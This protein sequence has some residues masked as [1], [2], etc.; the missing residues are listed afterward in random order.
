MSK[1]I[2]IFVL[3]C[4][5]GCNMDSSTS[6]QLNKTP[7]PE[8]QNETPKPKDQPLSEL[9][10]DEYPQILYGIISLRDAQK[11]MQ[12]TLTIDVKAETV[13]QTLQRG[14]DVNLPPIG[15]TVK[16]DLMNCTGYLATAN[17]TFRGLNQEEVWTAELTEETKNTNFEPKLL[18]CKE[19]PNDEFTRK[20]LSDSIFFIAPSQEDRKKVRNVR[21]PDW[22]NILQT[23]PFEWRKIAKLSLTATKKQTEECIGNW[24]DSDGDG[25]IDIL[26][27]CA[28]NDENGGYIYERVL[29]LKDGSWREVWQTVDTK[30]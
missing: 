29:Q 8:I 12:T 10:S 27:L 1:L 6:A 17:I 18:E 4:A 21:N 14:F 7:K 20:Y 3:L 26:T 15:S 9:S 25:K 19:N 11:N 23:I 16:M 24:L 30:N 28:F 22:K 13:R 5:A 2:C